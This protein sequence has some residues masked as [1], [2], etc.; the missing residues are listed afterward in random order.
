MLTCKRLTINATFCPVTTCVHDQLLKIC[1][2]AC[3]KVRLILLFLEL[4]CSHSF[5]LSSS[6]YSRPAWPL[7]NSLKQSTSL[8]IRLGLI[9]YFQLRYATR[10]NSQPNVSFTSILQPISVEARNHSNTARTS[11]EPPEP[12]YVTRGYI[13]NTS[14][15]YLCLS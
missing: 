4:P 11:I 9:S 12:A 8:S 7:L 1:C 13:Y 5:F 2:L 15:I 10:L 14:C 3:R 6:V